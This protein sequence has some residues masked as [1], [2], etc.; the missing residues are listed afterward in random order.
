MVLVEH[1]HI[2]GILMVLQ[3]LI[4]LKQSQLIRL[5]ILQV[6]LVRRFQMIKIIPLPTSAT[7]IETQVVA[8]RGGGGRS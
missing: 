7:D 4:E 8:A 2:N 6:L 1:Y 3:K 5:Q